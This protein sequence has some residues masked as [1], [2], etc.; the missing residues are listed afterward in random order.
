MKHNITLVVLLS[1]FF[2]CCSAVSIDGVIKQNTIIKDTPL[3]LN[4]E[5]RCTLCGI[6][7][8]EIEGFMEENITDTEL[9]E[10]ITKDVCDHLGEKAKGD[11]SDLVQLIPEIIKMISNKNSVNVVC[12]EK[13]YCDKPI[14][15]GPDPQGVPTYVVNLD[16]PANIRWKHICSNSTYKSNM[17]L[18]IAGLADI[19]PPAF[20]DIGIALNLLYYPA[21]YAAEIRGCAEEMGIEYGWLTLVNLGYEATDACT[22][23]VAQTNDNKILHVRNMDFWDGI[24][25]TN[26][27]KNLVLTADYQKGGKTL[28]HT[29]TFAGYVGVL[30]G[31]KPGGFS[32]SIDTRDYPAGVFQLFY[33][34]IAAIKEKNATLVSFL[35]RNVLSRDNNFESAIK[36]LSNDLL[37]ADV[38]YIVGGVSAGQGAVITRNR[39]NATDV[40]RLDATSGRWFEVQTNYDH[41]KQP[42]WYD[43]RVV[44]AN[45]AMK[46]LGRN[47][48]TLDNLFHKVLSVKPVLNLQSTFSMLTC[49]ADDTYISYARNC[50]YPCAE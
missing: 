38:Y 25:L 1:I 30:S 5:A 33:E 6:V 28:F 11:C 36:D 41:W 9:K 20:L 13:G 8:N 39:H 31:M 18:L 27:L 49:A 7:V 50:P 17:Q 43:D 2:L 10:I 37:I 22:S 12:V 40:W 35:T 42:P 29:T 26:H 34:I 46:A 4:P 32:I 44:P 3:K 19:F 23:I 21:E 14:T 45:Q 15:Y 24:W 47:D 48:L 16:L